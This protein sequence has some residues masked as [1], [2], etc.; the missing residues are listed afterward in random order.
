M[1]ENDLLIPLKEL[2]SHGTGLEAQDINSK[3]IDV[4]LQD[5]YHIICLNHKTKQKRNMPFKAMYGN[6]KQFWT[7]P[8]WEYMFSKDDFEIIKEKYSAAYGAWV[9]VAVSEPDIQQ[10]NKKSEHK[11]IKSKIKDDDLEELHIE[12]G[13]GREY[14]EISSMSSEE[15]IQ[16]IKSNQDRLNDLIMHKSKDVQ[17]ITE[18]LVDTTKDAALINHAALEEAMRLGDSEAKKLTQELV[19]ST[20]DMV[21]SST[22]L[23]FSDIF[24]DEMMHT[25]VEKSN[26]TIVQH[27][28]RVFLTG[29]AFF[30]YYNKLVS[31]S[32]AI[33]KLRISFASKYRKYYKKLLP[34][35]HP[36]EITLERVF[37]QGMRA[38]PPELINHWAVGFLIHDVGK[39]AAVEYHEGEA[40]YDR[41][42]VI[43]HVKQGYSSIMNKTNYPRE[44]GLITGYH[45]EYYGDSNGYGYFRAYL[46]QYRKANPT[47][48]QDYCI[49]Y[50]LEPLLD[51]KALSFFPAKVLEIIDVYDSL[52]DP[53][54]VYKK[55]MQPDEAL[56]M[57]LEEFI[58]R[59]FKLDVILF[60]IF[61]DYIRDT[62]KNDQAN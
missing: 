52:T 15:Q 59:H 44:A 22:N 26:G 13:Y 34:H 29:M 12:L 7:Q 19:N 11:K 24:N 49:A 5:D 38:I 35:I 40:A 60:D 43:D 32:S 2:L 27:M 21:K 41:N 48:K 23:I 39:A 36:D 17:V 30:S 37:Y 42:I 47:A 20:C 33:Q 46:N 4:L 62:K 50:E 57:M 61:A 6:N 55:P 9:P 31:Q 18:A 16:L 51:F 14:E 54:R 10:K 45:H 28:T 3:V 1:S 8:G 58:D 25:L 56:A 53:N